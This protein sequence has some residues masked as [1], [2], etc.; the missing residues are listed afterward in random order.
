MP[1]TVLNNTPLSPAAVRE[2]HAKCVV[3]TR[4]IESDN[5]T[6]GFWKE[7]ERLDA[8]LPESHDPSQDSTVDD[9][10]IPDEKRKVDPSRSALRRN[11]TIE[12]ERITSCLRVC[13]LKHRA[14]REVGG[15]KRLPGGQIR[16]CLDA[17]GLCARTLEFNLKSASSW[18]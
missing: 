6:E 14:V 9:P 11:R 1:P 16:R 8:H 10:G 4:G 5:I 7:N 13:E 12:P 3:F 15:G 18:T 2:F 17:N